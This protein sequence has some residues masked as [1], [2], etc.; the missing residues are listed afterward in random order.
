MFGRPNSVEIP[1]LSHPE[2]H[3]CD[4]DCV[5]TN[6]GTTRQIMQQQSTHVDDS[7]S[8]RILANFCCWNVY[9]LRNK[10]S[11]RY[12]HIRDTIN[13]PLLFRSESWTLL[14]LTHPQAW[15]FFIHGNSLQCIWGLLW[16]QY[17][18]HDCFS[19]EAFIVKKHLSWMGHISHTCEKCC[20]AASYPLATTPMV[21]KERH[22]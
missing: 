4:C 10:V 16:L 6:M 22:M 1:T 9:F 2:D 3:I 13:V 14:L 11:K 20:S 19:T 7:T 8:C 21:G 18:P 5:S 17:I 15:S 12:W